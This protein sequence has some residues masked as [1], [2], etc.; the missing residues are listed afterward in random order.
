MAKRLAGIPHLALLC[1]HYEGVDERAVEAFAHEEV[2]I[3]DYVLTGGEPAALVL[4]DAISRFVPGVVGDPLSATDA[5]HIGLVSRVVPGDTL[6]DEARTLAL[7]LA[8][9]APLALALTKRALAFAETATLEEALDHE[10]YL[11]GIAGD[12]ADF[13]EG[14]TA[15]REKR[16]P[17]FTGE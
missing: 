5:A 8:A 10:A 15:F 4:L 14:S 1:G 9:G 12:S 16:P 7:R 3:G 17:R 2:S 13:A 6:M 11:Q